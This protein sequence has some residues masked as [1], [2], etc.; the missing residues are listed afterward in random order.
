MYTVD[1]AME[2]ASR[3]CTKLWGDREGGREGGE[4]GRE[5]GWKGGREEGGREVSEEEVRRRRVGGRACGREAG[6]LVAT[7][8][9]QN[10][11]V[12]VQYQSDSIKWHILYQTHRAPSA[13]ATPRGA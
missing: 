1:R 6:S 2:C 5:E 3:R 7:L 10:D 9:L 12:L 13:C 8:D 4:G 11:H